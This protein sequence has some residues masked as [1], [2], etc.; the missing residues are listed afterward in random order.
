M[1]YDRVVQ[2]VASWCSVFTNVALL[3]RE[4]GEECSQQEESTHAESIAARQSQ[5]ELGCVMVP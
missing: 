5:R 1:I 4:L 3:R 2:S